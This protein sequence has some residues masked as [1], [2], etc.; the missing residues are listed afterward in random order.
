MIFERQLILQELTL[1]PSTEWLP[2]SKGWLMLRV[3]EGTGFWL[4]H[5]TDA[6]QLTVG[7]C[8]IVNGKASGILRAGQLGLLQL[9]FFIVQTQLLLDLLTVAEWH[10][11]KIVLKNRVEPVSFFANNELVGQKFKRLAGLSHN[12]R[13]IERCALLQLWAAA[14][15]CLLPV[16]APVAG[17]PG[18][19]RDRFRKIISEISEAEF[20]STLPAVFAQQIR[21]SERQFNTLFIEEFGVTP[22][23]HQAEM[24]PLFAPQGP[25]ENFQTKIS[26]STVTTAVGI[27]PGTGRFNRP[28]EEHDS[29]PAAVAADSGQEKQEEYLHHPRKPRTVHKPTKENPRL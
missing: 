8:M 29:Y 4:Q 14:I 6:R 28:G 11:L 15:A 18:K 22:R 23:E 2:S 13:P 21:C 7:D 1:Q 27:A 25:I 5:G 10:Q 20:C 16:N 12:D 9:Q 24:S 3:A 26:R 19:T 17:N